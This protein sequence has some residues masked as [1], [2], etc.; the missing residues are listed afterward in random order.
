[1]TETCKDCGGK[2]D[3][4]GTTGYCHHCSGR[5]IGKIYGLFSSK[6]SGCKAFINL[7]LNHL[8][9]YLASYVAGYI[10]ADGSV[11]KGYL[12]ITSKDKKHLSL[13]SNIIGGKLSLQN[14]AK[15]YYQL[16]LR[17]IE[18]QYI[19]PQIIPYMMLKRKKAICCLEYT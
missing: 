10:D 7:P 12:S 8:P 1:M 6:S 3:Y 14:K 11:G 4:R 18:R 17:K 16:A 13:I 2:R 19:L 9:Q 15:K 5:R